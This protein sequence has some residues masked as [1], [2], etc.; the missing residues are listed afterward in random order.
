MTRYPDLARTRFRLCAAVCHELG[1]DL[2]GSATPRSGKIA[3]W[4]IESEVWYKVAR[5]LSVGT[6]IRTTRNVYAL[7]NRW[8][9]YPSVGVRYAF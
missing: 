3:S 2:A 6:Y 4:E 8:V 1:N 7:S 5:D 9:V